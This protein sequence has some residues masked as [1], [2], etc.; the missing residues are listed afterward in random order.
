GLRPDGPTR[1]SE[2]P[3]ALATD[4]ATVTR[5]SSESGQWNASA[6]T[7][8]TVAIRALLGYDRHVPGRP[9]GDRPDLNLVADRVEQP[10]VEESRPSSRPRVL[11]AASLAI[12]DSAASPEEL[13]L[14]HV[15]L[16][17]RWLLRVRLADEETCL[18]VLAASGARSL[19]AGRR[20]VVGPSIRLVRARED[21][22]GFG[23][24]SIAEIEGVIR[25]DRPGP[26]SVRRLP[27]GTVRIVTSTG[28][29][30][31]PDWLG[32][33]LLTLAADAGS[34]LPSRQALEQSG[35][36]PSG[37]VRRLQRAVGRSLVT[38]GLEP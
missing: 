28:F 17:E 23:G 35:T 30:L 29:A 9:Q 24:E 19:Q 26:I 18:L 22:A 36:V 5:R 15:E 3:A 37:M 2:R 38:I 11:A 31:D 13:A 12:A 21:D 10:S 1:A 4:G 7:T 20:R 6:S 16:P 27:D 34:G 14:V 8:H 32:G 33:P 25:L